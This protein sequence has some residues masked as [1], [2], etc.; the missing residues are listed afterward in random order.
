MA[1]NTLQGKMISENNDV[2]EI[3][4]SLPLSVFTEDEQLAVLAVYVKEKTDHN[5]D[6][7]PTAINTDDEKINFTYNVADSG[8]ADIHDTV[9]LFT[10][11]TM[12][13]TEK[14]RQEAQKNADIKKND[15][16]YSAPY[17][18]RELLKIR[19]QILSIRTA[20]KYNMF[21]IPGV[22][23]EAHELHF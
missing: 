6:V 22:Q 15:A 3:T 9:D 17:S 8:L 13:L 4:I 14:A 20:G 5:G 7:L 11:V 19:S 16:S 21:D 18:P 23:R 2:S 10:D 1:D 12:K